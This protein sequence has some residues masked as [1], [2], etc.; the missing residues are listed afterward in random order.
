MT[1]LSTEDEPLDEQGDAPQ[2]STDKMDFKDSSDLMNGSSSDGAVR[3]VKVQD[4]ELR[5]DLVK[6]GEG[7]EL[8][9][10][11]IENASFCVC[12]DIGIATFT[13]VL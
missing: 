3:M 11:S 10:V 13:V 12:G 5:K 6:A 8:P 4:S 9:L 1:R 2:L 7:E